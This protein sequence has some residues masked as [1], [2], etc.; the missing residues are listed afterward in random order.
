MHIGTFFVRAFIV[1]YAANTRISRYADPH[2]LD[3]A[4]KCS[5]ANTHTHM[6]IARGTIDEH[7]HGFIC[8]M[9]IGT[10]FFFKAFIVRYAAD[11][12]TASHTRFY[13]QAYS[14]RYP[15]PSSAYQCVSTLPFF[16]Q[17]FLL[18]PEGKTFFACTLIACLAAFSWRKTGTA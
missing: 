4:D 13:R 14:A 2:T 17:R 18:V 16:F 8:S 15:R 9:H 6:S 11:K 1:R 3:A 7:M 10:S 12:R 5:H